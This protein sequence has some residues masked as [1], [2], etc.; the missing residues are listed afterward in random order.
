ML[1][2]KL[3]SPQS[4]GVVTLA[5]TPRLGRAMVET[6]VLLLLPAGPIQEGFGLGD[7]NDL[8]KPSL[9][10]Q[11]VREENPA[12]RLGQGTR[13]PNMLRRIWFSWL[14]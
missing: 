6:P 13:L 2:A 10:A 8:G 14:R 9:N 3:I 11:A 4:L 1:G 5:R 7:G 12:V